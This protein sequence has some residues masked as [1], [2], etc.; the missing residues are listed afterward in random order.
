MV[1]LMQ[2]GFFNFSV[3][4]LALLVGA[5][6][7]VDDFLPIGWDDMKRWMGVNEGNID[8]FV[9][10]DVIVSLLALFVLLGVLS[11]IIQMIV[12][13]FGFRLS[14]D[15]NGLRRVRGLFTRS[16]IVIPRKRIQ[17]ATVTR[18]VIARRFGFAHVAVQTLGGG[19]G[20]AG[21]V[22]DLA[23]LANAEET[24]QM[25][26]LAGNFTEPVQTHYNRV[27]PPHVWMEVMVNSILLTIMVIGVS[28]FKPA[29]LW[30]LLLLPLVAFLS[31]L[32][33]RPHAWVLEGGILAVRR[34]WFSQKQ[35]FLPVKNIQSLSIERGP[36]HRLAGLAGLVIDTA[37]GS[38]FGVR[39]ANLRHETAR[40]LLRVLRQTA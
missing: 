35:V 12:T 37:G 31:W 6:Q 34:G 36:L 3:V 33:H 38:H 7:V 24:A 39:I 9:R 26:A 5:L 17:L 22:Q 28:V 29:A 18:R 1:R 30:G 21:G 19:S 16:E 20:A 2:A 27:A 8:G 25:L 32:S 23:P 14:V 13:N 10:I 40:K 15:G 4:W 11:G